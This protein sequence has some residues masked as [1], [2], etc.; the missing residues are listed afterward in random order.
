M[1]TNSIWRF[2]LLHEIYG[3][4]VIGISERDCSHFN[5]SFSDKTL[6]STVRY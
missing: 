6:H 3:G 1:N 4:P 5:N 2:T